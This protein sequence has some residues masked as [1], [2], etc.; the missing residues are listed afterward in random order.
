MT[1]NSH[2]LFEEAKVLV[3]RIKSDE[4]RLMEIFRLLQDGNIYKFLGFESV[5]ELAIRGLGMSESQAGTLIFVSR[6]CEEF[7]ALQ[8]A[9]E[10]GKLNVTKARKIAA[11]LEPATCDDWIGKA[12]TLSQRDLERELV[13]SHPEILIREDIKS[14][15]KDRSELRCGISSEFEK[16]LERARNLKSRNQKAYASIEETLH[17]AL[18]I[19]LEKCDPVRRAERITAKKPAK[20]SGVGN[21]SKHSRERKNSRVIPAA[22]R[23][24]VDLRDRRQCQDMSS[25][26][27]CC[28]ERF[29]D[30]HHVVPI[31]DGGDHSLGNLI[32]LCRFHHDMRHDF[33]F[34][35]YRRCGDR[36]SAAISGRLLRSQ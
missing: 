13:K 5:R 4:A 26:R 35:R 31:S 8:S 28:S 1:L 24:Q 29:T 2:P 12:E 21:V 6:K 7:P 3:A 17:A 23:H 20:S 30:I 32:T 27:K 16:D 33:G 15:C 22:A 34:A 19:Y 18:K 36:R 11:V 9:I 14:V 25:G 10:T